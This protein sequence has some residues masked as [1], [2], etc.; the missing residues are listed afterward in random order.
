[1]VLYKLL[2]PLTLLKEN[3]KTST[4]KNEFKDADAFTCLISND[5]L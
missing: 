3:K 2:L 1:M 4:S 5:I